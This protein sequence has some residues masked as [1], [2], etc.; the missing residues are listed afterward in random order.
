[1][2]NRSN[3]DL[4]IHY[5][6]HWPRYTRLSSVLRP[7]GSWRE[8]MNYNSSFNLIALGRETEESR[9]TPPPPHPNRI[10]HL[11]HRY[12]SRPAPSRPTRR[13]AEAR[14]LTHSHSHHSARGPRGVITAV[15]GL[16]ILKVQDSGKICRCS[17][18]GHAL[19]QIWLTENLFTAL[20]SR[21]ICFLFVDSFE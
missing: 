3:V 12:Q 18:F 7:E 4:N 10:H 6:L 17:H 9:Y 11:L 2:T 16:Q 1:M 21:Y 5:R 19:E 14:G 13:P 20:W 15:T 8:R